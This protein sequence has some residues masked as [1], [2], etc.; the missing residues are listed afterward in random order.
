MRFLLSLLDKYSRCRRWGLVSFQLG[1]GSKVWFDKV[2]RTQKSGVPIGRDSIINAGIDFDREGA[3]IEC[4]HGCYIG[5]NYLVR[6][7]RISLKDDLV[8]RPYS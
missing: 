6:A 1:A 3:R 7:E 5:A 2:S 4:G 8:L